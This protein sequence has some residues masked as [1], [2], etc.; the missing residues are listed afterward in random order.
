MRHK[1]KFRGMLLKD[2]RITIPLAVR[3]E[4]KLE[5]GMFFEAKVVDNDTIQI[6]FL[7]V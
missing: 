7:R 3:Q 1:D 4:L 5:E 6:K 2:G